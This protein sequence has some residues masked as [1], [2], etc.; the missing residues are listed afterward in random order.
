MISKEDKKIL[1]AYVRDFNERN[2]Y[3]VAFR[4]DL[5]KLAIENILSDIQQ[6]ETKQQKAVDKLE[7][8]IEM[9][10]DVL[11]LCEADGK[12]AKYKIENLK[13]EIE[14][15]KKILNIMKGEE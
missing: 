15:F 9:L 5:L 3:A 11:D 12:I 1:E 14:D 4:E 7:E 2:K 6:L 13:E 8:K 10:E